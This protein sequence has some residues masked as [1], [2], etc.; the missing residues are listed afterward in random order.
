MTIVPKEY[1]YKQ[2]KVVVVVVSPQTIRTLGA[3][4]T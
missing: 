1:E 4:K 3:N 2:K